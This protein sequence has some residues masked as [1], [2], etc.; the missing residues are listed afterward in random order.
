MPKC[1]ADGAGPACREL[2]TAA[3]LACTWCLAGTAPM[4]PGRRSAQAMPVFRPCGQTNATISARTTAL[5]EPLATGPCSIPL[6]VPGP[7]HVEADPQQ[8][9][10]GCGCPAA[11]ARPAPPHLYP[12]TEML[13]CRKSGALMR[14]SLIMGICA[15]CRSWRQMGP[16]SSCA[17]ASCRPPPPLLDARPYTKKRKAAAGIMMH[18]SFAANL[19]L[20]RMAP[21]AAPVRFLKLISP[22]RSLFVIFSWNFTSIG[23]STPRR[24]L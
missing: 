9:E 2:P 18:S 14:T 12:E 21:V 10:P 6:P 7:P 1:M 11:R 16:L 4:A 17:Q 20:V 8:C 19:S 13:P 22:S 5:C 3:W 24:S 15:Y 23:S